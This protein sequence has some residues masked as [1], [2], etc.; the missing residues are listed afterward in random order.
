MADSKKKLNI[1]LI[2]GLVF[3]VIGVGTGVAAFLVPKE[4]AAEVSFPQVPSEKP[5]EKSYSVLT[6]EEISDAS[7][8]SSPIY[9]IQTPNGTDGARP[10]AGL[11]TAGVV[12]E[13]IA[14][15]GITRFAAL[16][17]NSEAAVI[18]PI[19]SLRLYYLEW[20][21]PFDC[22]IVH[23]G[24]SDDAMAAVKSYRHLSENYTYMYRGTRGVRRWN[25]LFTTGNY[26]SSMSADWGYDSSNPKGFARMTPAE[27][28]KDYV[29]SLA[30][31]PLNITK[32]TDENT[33]ALAAKTD[34]INLNFGNVP[35]YNVH[36]D[37]DL[38]TNTYRRSYGSGAAHEIY[39]CPDENLGEKNPEDVCSLTT[40]APD[41]VAVMMVQEK[42]AWDNYH[43]DI[44]AIGSGTAYVFQNGKAI[45]GTWEKASREDQIKFLDSEGAEIKLAPGQTFVSAVPNYGSVEY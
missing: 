39:S 35:A 38:E 7:L 27:A 31:A 36:Y 23:A 34:S 28:K 41:V 40:M 10:Q 1:L 2:L 26:L 45:K 33:S 15:A 42:R 37:Y 11:D 25:N 13:A 44:T 14:E 9:C 21:T 20:D 30:T 19:R 17:Q 22:I 18:G 4:E 16:Y 5:A 6:G 43:E 29:D 3:L 24:G 32:A 12:F 8:N